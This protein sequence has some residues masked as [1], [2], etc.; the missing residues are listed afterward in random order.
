V[1]ASRVVR[2]G[3]CVLDS[4]VGLVRSARV[5]SATC[6]CACACAHVCTC[7][8]CARARAR[9]RACACMY[10]YVHV[11]V[12]ACTCVCMRARVCACVHV[13]ARARVRACAC[14][15]S[16]ELR[17]TS[18]RARLPLR[19][20][21]NTALGWGLRGWRASRAQDRTW[22]TAGLCSGSRVA[23]DGERAA[24]TQRS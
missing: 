20:A 5:G 2:L 24:R 3:W 11:C 18:V 7:M 17:R 4:A 13:R 8:W 1:G 19:T 16:C 12:H 21:H 14:T 9:V 6:T 10:V 22:S 23:R 15:W